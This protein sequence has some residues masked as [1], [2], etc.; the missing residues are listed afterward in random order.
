MDFKKT[1]NNMRSKFLGTY[2]ANKNYV[3]TGLQVINLTQQILNKEYK[4]IIK[5]STNILDKI[6][7]TSYYVSDLFSKKDGWEPLFKPYQNS[8]VPMYLHILSKFPHKTITLYTT[9]KIYDLPNNIQLISY[10]PSNWDRVETILFNSNINNKEQILNFLNKEMFLTVNSSIIQ[11]NYEE[12]LQIKPIELDTYS[13]EMADDLLDYINKSID[14]N[15]PR[16]II[17]AGEPGAGK[18]CVAAALINKL[19]LKTLIIKD[20]QQIGI[21]NIINIVELFDIK[22]ILIDDLD[23]AGIGTNNKILG[24]L[25]N[26]RKTVKV[27]I[28][29]VNSLNKFHKALIRPGRFD[30]II[31][32]NKLDDGVINNILGEDLIEYFDKVSNWPIAYINEF[33]LSAKLEGKDKIDKIIKDLQKRISTDQI[34]LDLETYLNKKTIEEL[35][36][37]KTKEEEIAYAIAMK[38]KSA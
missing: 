11:I 19:N 10:L 21:E 29:T 36:K 22:A 38:N 1:F 27:I 26:I 20:F 34:D 5:T 2:I 9:A 23:H 35:K 4:E 7:S 13:S 3:N 31:I 14:L 17:L 6:S 32:S 16:S 37:E 18:S 12:T 24:F 8:M 33:V 15:I 28:A 30:K 25:E